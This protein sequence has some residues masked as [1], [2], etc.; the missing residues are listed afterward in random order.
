MEGYRKVNPRFFPAEDQTL[1]SIEI[2]GFLKLRE[3][4]KKH[5]NLYNFMF[6][7]ISLNN[8]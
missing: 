2:V 5:I 7:R 8:L 3:H 4:Y 1:T 6:V